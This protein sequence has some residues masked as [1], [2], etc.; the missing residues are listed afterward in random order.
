LIRVLATVL[1][2]VLALT[3][4]STRP[5]H[6]EAVPS[7]ATIEALVDSVDDGVFDANQATTHGVSTGDV[8]KFAQ[9]FQAFGGQLRGI[10]IS[11]TDRDGTAA[12]A[13]RA[14]C[15][16]TT[17]VKSGDSPTYQV[18]VWLNSC[19]TNVLVGILNQG[20]GAAVVVGALVALGTLGA[21]AALSVAGGI[22]IIGANAIATCAAAGRGVLIYVRI[23]PPVGGWCVSQ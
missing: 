21:G 23:N 22:I 14:A 5:S 1:S 10:E 18:R 15:E 12:R 17:N 3:V 6:A 13:A 2:V 9:G 20:G 8:A 11:V 4:V 19:N 16:G 7:V